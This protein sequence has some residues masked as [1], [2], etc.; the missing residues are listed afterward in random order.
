MGHLLVVQPG[1]TPPLGVFDGAC[2]LD[3]WLGYWLGYWARTRSMSSM[4]LWVASRI[5]DRRSRM[6]SALVV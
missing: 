6:V 2:P 5:E 4:W 3:D 1:S